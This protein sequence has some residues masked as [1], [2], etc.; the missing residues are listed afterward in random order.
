MTLTPIR[1]DLI[2]VKV[3]RIIIMDLR[4]LNSHDRKLLARELLRK[5]E[6]TISENPV[7]IFM[8]GLPGA[9]KTELTLRLIK[10]LKERPLRVDM[11]EI[12]SYIKGYS[13]DRAS[14]FRADATAVLEKIFD[15]ATKKKHWLIMDGTFS[16]E[17]KAI[18]NIERCLKYGYKV[19][20]YYVHQEPIR[21]WEFTKSREAI[22]KR[23]ISV[24]G[25]IKTYYAMR[26]NLRDL[27]SLEKDIA[28]NAIVKDQDNREKYTIQ[29]SNSIMT[30]LGE[31][32]TDEGLRGILV[33]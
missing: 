16:H 20:L 4:K 10:E 8:A 17:T 19:S 33:V 13:P 3:A 18:A 28:I 24:N 12:A 27:V 31:D 23:S 6:F 11:D 21:A 30:L 2:G 7:A 29:G 9:G 32:L 22:E 14:D 5:Y 15:E 1:F 25:F 26:K